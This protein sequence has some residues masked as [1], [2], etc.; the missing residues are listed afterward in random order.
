MAGSDDDDE[1]APSFK[2]FNPRAAGARRHAWG[3]SGVEADD[4]SD[5]SVQDDDDVF[6]PHF[7]DYGQPR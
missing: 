6:F 5:D 7:G 4:D 2:A 3:D 1:A